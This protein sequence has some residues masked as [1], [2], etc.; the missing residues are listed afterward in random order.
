MRGTVVE[1]SDKY[2]RL[3]LAGTVVADELV[4]PRGC[5]LSITS[6]GALTCSSPIT[7]SKAVVDGCL[8]AD[9]I[10]D[11]LVVA[12]HA[13]VTVRLPSSLSCL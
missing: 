1:I 2:K 8:N 12:A 10:C 13:R 7:C 11:E 4:I 9:V 3:E 6:S 5:V